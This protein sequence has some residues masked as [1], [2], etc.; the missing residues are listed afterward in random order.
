MYIADQTQ[1][2]YV[3][4]Q[5]AIWRKEELYKII[6]ERETAWEFEKLGSMRA[7]AYKGIY[8]AI[9]RSKVVLNKSE[10]IPYI[11]TGIVKGKW[12]KE[13]PELFERNNIYIDY[14]KRGF[15]NRSVHKPLQL[16]LKHFI[17]TIPNLFYNYFETLLI[18]YWL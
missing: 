15:W 17:T 12:I 18:K 8:L 13:V 5:A 10:I 11:F 14:S 6:R 1:K 4:C 7:K 2:Y 3:S 9:D 16:R